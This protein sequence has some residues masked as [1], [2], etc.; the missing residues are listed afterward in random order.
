MSLIESERAN[1]LMQELVEEIEWK[2][3]KIFIFG[4]E[5]LQPRLSAWFGGEGKAY[6]Y[7]GLKLPPREWTPKL[8]EIKALIEKASGREFNSAT[9]K[10][11]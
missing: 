8:F 7:S 9:F 3:E 5:V 1:K 6:S 10:L 11:L 4:R 2:Q